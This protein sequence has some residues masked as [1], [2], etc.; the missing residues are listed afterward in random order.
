MSDP[1]RQRFAPYLSDLADRMRLKDWK[2]ILSDD[3]P[4]KDEAAAMVNPVYGR[5][6]ASVRL[7]Q[8]FL[9]SDSEAQ[10]HYLVHELLHC[11]LEP[12]WMIAMDAIPHAVEA[13]FTRMAE[14]AVDGIADVLAPLMPLPWFDE[15]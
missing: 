9:D 8:H 2:I 12:A 7:S 4:D 1:S 3:P 15:S 6:V 10:R 14:Y 5:K 11:H 13:P